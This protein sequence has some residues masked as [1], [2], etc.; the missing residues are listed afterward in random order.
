MQRAA[1]REE[2]PEKVEEEIKHDAGSTATVSRKWYF[3]SLN[4]INVYCF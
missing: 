1:A 4:S 3:Y 2:K